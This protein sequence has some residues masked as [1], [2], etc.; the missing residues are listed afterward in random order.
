MS[1]GLESKKL[2]ARS[3]GESANAVS[4]L[5]FQV[6]ERGDVTSS[7]SCNLGQRAQCKDGDDREQQGELRSRR[8]V[9][10][11]LSLSIYVSCVQLR[12]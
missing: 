10:D 4:H 12:S 11:F 3:V 5:A 6:S 1:E 2:S 8:H 7:K 9:V